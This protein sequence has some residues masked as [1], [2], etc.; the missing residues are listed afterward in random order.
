MLVIWVEIHKMLVGILNREDLIR[1]LLQKQSDLGQGCLP[2]P[3]SQATGVQNLNIFDNVIL[4]AQSDLD[5]HQV[6]MRVCLNTSR[7]NMLL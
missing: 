5:L 3:F 1:L 4:P 6:I 2:R 7:V